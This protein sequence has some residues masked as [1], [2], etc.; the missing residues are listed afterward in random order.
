MMHSS[1]QDV[2]TSLPTCHFKEVFRSHLAPAPFNLPASHE[3]VAF[4]RPGGRGIFLPPGT[5]FLLLRLAAFLVQVC[6]SVASV[7]NTREFGGRLMKVSV[8]VLG[9]GPGGWSVPV[10]AGS[11]GERSWCAAWGSVPVLSLSSV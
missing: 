3:T 8:S 9:V 4:E 2:F 6:S 10:C 11:S 5:G 7:V 1:L